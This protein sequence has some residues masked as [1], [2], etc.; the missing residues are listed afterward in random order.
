L[1][2]RSATEFYSK[3]LNLRLTFVKDAAGRVVKAIQSQDN[4]TIEAPKIE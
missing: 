2:P 1:L 3:E 4:S